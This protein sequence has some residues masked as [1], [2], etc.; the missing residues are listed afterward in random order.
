MGQSVYLIKLQDL[1]H[2]LYSITSSVLQKDPHR[3]WSTSLMVST[4]W[5]VSFVLIRRQYTYTDLLANLLVDDD[6]HE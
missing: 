4:Y 2:T 6:V 1:Q 3:C 5:T